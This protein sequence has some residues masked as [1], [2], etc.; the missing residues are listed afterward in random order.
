MARS[1]RPTIFH[2][3]KIALAAGAGPAVE[4]AFIDPVLLSM[5]IQLSLPG[6]S[7]EPPSP[8]NAIVSAVQEMVQSPIDKVSAPG[9]S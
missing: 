7:R 3:L 4:Q 2:G 9:T 8:A 6:F 5:V 1:V